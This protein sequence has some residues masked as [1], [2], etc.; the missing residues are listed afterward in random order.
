VCGFF[1]GH[2][3]H[4]I[5]FRVVWVGIAAEKRKEETWI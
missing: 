4:C 2:L 5:G 3:V 1:I